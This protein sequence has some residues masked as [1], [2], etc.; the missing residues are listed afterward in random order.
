MALRVLSSR[1][2]GS[3]S[4]NLIGR[5][6][7]FISQ[8]KAAESEKSPACSRENS[9][10]ISRPPSE[11]GRNQYAAS[12]GACTDCS[13][14]PAGTYQRNESSRPD[15]TR[16]ATWYR[17]WI[18]AGDKSA[19]HEMPACSS[20]GGGLSDPRNVDHEKM[21][22][23]AGPGRRSRLPTAG[24]IDAA[25]LRPVSTAVTQSTGNSTVEVKV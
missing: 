21:S 20:A 10:S 13:T 14:Y 4:G 6:C 15:C 18:N 3:I 24:G 11:A 1:R 25:A 16:Y 8:A 23:F 7:R 9:I 2:S 22:W 5:A 12:C 19:R 17:I